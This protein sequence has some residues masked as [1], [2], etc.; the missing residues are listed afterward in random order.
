M[1]MLSLSELFRAETRDEVMSTLLAGASDLLLK[2]TSW[3]PGQ[4]VRTVLVTIA[5]KFSD[6]DKQWIEI[7]KG[8][9]LDYATGPWLSLLAWSLY[10]VT[11][12]QAKAATSGTLGFR[13]Q[14]GSD[15]VNEPAGQLIF[16]HS[17]TGKTYRNVEPV[18]FT[19]MS[20]GP[21]AIV[22]DELGTASDAAPNM[23][24]VMVTSVPGVTCYNP[25]AVLG[26]D[27]ETDE[28]IRARCR[29]KLGSLSPNGPKEAY[30]FVA[31]TPYFED[32]TPCAPTVVPITRTKVSLDIVTGLVT[33]YIASAD[34]AVSPTDVAIVDDALDVWCTP[35][36]TASQ[37][38]AAPQLV[39]PITYQVW[40]SGSSLTVDQ[41]KNEIADALIS[42]FRKVPIGGYVIE[43]D[44][45]R[46]IVGM[47]ENAITNAVE[48]IVK[49]VVS[50]P[51]SDL[52]PGENVVSVLGVLTPTVTVLP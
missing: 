37:A 15:P 16:A 42:Y 23:I 22:A 44:P 25:A 31:T 21:I 9:L 6:R 36:L 33:L 45:G 27:E 32:G 38:V 13:I 24:T 30:H 17:V 20:E 12:K 18:N 29:A 50:S 8:G 46:I 47:L 35:W 10:R 49:V 1:A 34:G 48:G 41:I 40:V 2:I 14:V 52:E 19:P 4:P 51:A 7:A 3:Q 28:D 5:Q 11:R 43:N 39:V 26:A